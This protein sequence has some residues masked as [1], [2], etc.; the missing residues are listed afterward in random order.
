MPASTFTIKEKEEIRKLYGL[1]LEQLDL[2]TFRKIH[3]ELRAKYHPDNFEHLDN[4]AVKEMATEKFQA[5]ELLSQKME[6]WLANAPPAASG[7]QTDVADYLRPDAFFAIKRLK[8]EILTAD[9]DLKYHLFGT[10]YR[11]L[12]FGDSFKIPGTRASIVIDED[13]AGRRIGFQESVRMYLTFGEEDS[14]EDMVEWLFDKVVGRA[15]KLLIAGEAVDL[16]P[17]KIINAIKKESL[18]RLGPAVEN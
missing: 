12:Q 2:E 7:Y 5:I 14:I 3:R 1:P 13:Y 17:E 11:W 16:D 15:T 10:Y 4:E 9:K 6:A 8:I 18:L